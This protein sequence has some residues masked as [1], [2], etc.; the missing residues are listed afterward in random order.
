MKNPKAQNKKWEKIK[1]EKRLKGIIALFAQIFFS[2]FA[3]F[4][5]SC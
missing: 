1:E 4:H 5:E 2:Y 3:E